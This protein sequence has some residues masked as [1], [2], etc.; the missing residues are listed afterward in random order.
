[1]KVIYIDLLFLINTAANYL[2]LLATSKICDIS[3]KRL[4]IL[5]AAV[6]GGIYS[7]FSALP[8][9]V[10]LNT[11]PIKAVFATVMVY[12]SFGLHRFFLRLLAIFI[13]VSAALGGIIYAVSLGSSG[14]F[15]AIGLR[16][17]AMSF[18]ITAGLISVIFRRT[19]KSVTETHAIH[20]ECFGKA[21]DFTA[22]VDTGNSLKDPI[23]G[24]A[25]II[26]CIKDM[27]S[28][29]PSELYQLISTLSPTDAFEAISGT[30]YS[31]MFRLI[32]YSSVGIQSGMLLAL[33]ANV[34]IDGKKAPK[35]LIA[36]SPTEVSDGGAYS[37]LMGI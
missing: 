6:I 30:V 34:Q 33:K 26:I 3:I 13:S 8:T 17:L 15:S 4:R 16:S 35:V 12:I 20:V 18:L 32:P 31:G 23:S 27:K 21:S 11:L 19:G 36:I 25:A 24:A 22:F 2:L 1:M 10:F 28:V 37:A 9:F 14:V 7:I 29:L 5:I